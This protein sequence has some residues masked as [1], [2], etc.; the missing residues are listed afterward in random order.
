MSKTLNWGIL[1][2]GT[3]AR[4]FARGVARSKSGRVVAIGSRSQANAD[5]FGDELNVPNRHGSYDALLAVKAAR[6]RKHLLCEKPIALNHEQAAQ[7]VAAAR[8]NDVFLMEAFMYRCHP[9]TQKIVELVKSKAVGDIKVIQATF[10]FRAPFDPKQRLWCNELGGGGILDVGCYPV[11]MARLI[12]GAAVGKE[13]AD[14]IAVTGAGQLNPITHVDEYAAASLS[15]AG[16]IIANVSTSLA[17]EQENVVRIYGTEGYILV[18]NPWMPSNDGSNTQILIYQN[19]QPAPRAI[20]VVTPGWLYAIEADTVAAHLDL[21]QAPSP[22][23]SWDDTLGNMKTLDQWR[24]A[25]G[26]VYHAE[27]N[28]RS[29]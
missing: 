29:S 7:I 27:R 22:A 9:Q 17:V 13:F 21:R 19:G 12:A 11:S 23:M 6:A 1:G 2:A 5:Q 4:T 25:I 10:G 26:L 16:G 14:P 28:A 3:I 15:F 20:E 18:A 24:K 8:E